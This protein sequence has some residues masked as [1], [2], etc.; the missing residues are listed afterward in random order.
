MGGAGVNIELKAGKKKK[1]L[2]KAAN[3]SIFKC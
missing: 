2:F 1:K 3:K